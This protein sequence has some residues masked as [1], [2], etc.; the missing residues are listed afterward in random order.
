MKWIETLEQVNALR[1]ELKARSAIY[2]IDA[3]ESAA[4]AFNRPLNHFY[5]WPYR[6]WVKV[7]RMYTAKM[8][9][10]MNECRHQGIPG[11]MPWGQFPYFRQ[12]MG[13]DI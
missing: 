8:Q 13:L 9:R 4:R 1:T 12:Q 11:N 3:K 5:H 2:Q 6:H 7:D 10:V